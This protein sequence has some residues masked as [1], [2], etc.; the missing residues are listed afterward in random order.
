MRQDFATP[1]RRPD[2]G[3]TVRERLLADLPVVERRLELADGPTAVL[4]GGEG[5]PLVLL[6][7]PG[8]HAVKW[9]RVIPALVREFRVIAPD[10]P[11]HGSSAAPPAGARDSSPEDGRAAPAA[12]LGWLGELLDA[13]CTT[14]PVLVGQIAA[15]ALAARFVAARTREVAHLVLVDTLGLAPFQPEPEFGAAITAFLGSPDER[16]FA[17]LWRRGAFDLDRLQGAM[18]EQ[19]EVFARY[20]LDCA[21]RPETRA[22]VHRLME[23]FGL[24]AVPSEELARIEVPTA[25]IWGRYDLATGLAVA[26]GA[27]ARYGW[28][29]HVVDDAG[30]DPALE[31]PER[32]VTA[33]R[34]LIASARDV[35]PG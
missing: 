3:G 26:E 15:G 16:T 34:A 32:F 1:R 21:R 7:G 33:L 4:E 28:A 24:P 8:E 29:L 31:Q 14:P 6:H 5:R 17:A 20:S 25:L 23:H 10:L 18:G 19:W 35:T 12:A 11:G 30:D 27:S 22:A 9:L 13:T 2:A